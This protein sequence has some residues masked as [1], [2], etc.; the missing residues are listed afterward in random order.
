MP[1]ALKSAA[2][3]SNDGRLEQI[4]WHSENDP[5]EAIL[6]ELTDLSTREVRTDAEQAR[7]ARLFDELEQLG[8]SEGS[9]SEDMLEAHLRE[10][11]RL[12]PIPS[13]EDSAAAAAAQKS[14]N[15][16]EKSTDDTKTS[17]KR[18]RKTLKFLPFAAALVLLI[19]T[20]TAQAYGENILDLFAKWSSEIFH[21]DGS[22]KP[23]ASIG[24]ND[25]AEGE[26]R[27][28]ATPQEMLDDFG[29][30]GQLIPTEVPEEF[31]APTCLA[32][33]DESGLKLQI[34]YESTDHYVFFEYMQISKENVGSVEK[35]NQAVVFWNFEGIK[36]YQLADN[37]IEKIA[38]ING[39]FE[40]H[41]SGN[42]TGEEMNRIIA[43]IYGG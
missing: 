30:R 29:I 11:H 7:L 20:V 35:N 2:F 37:G 32:S 24:H 16:M 14:K 36:H 18:S 19:G 8:R 27:E 9:L 41:A 23:E 17:S 28:Y 1:D 38:W 21:L 34:L 40:C 4:P 43:S 25:L 13:T 6:D 31:G 10:L 33:N 26:V 5:E 42:V 22:A 15:K 3:G 39:N 12:A